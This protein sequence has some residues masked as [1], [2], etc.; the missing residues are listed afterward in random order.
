MV[1][2]ETGSNKID[3]EAA[4]DLAGEIGRSNDTP[5]LKSALKKS[6]RGF[7]DPRAKSTSPAKVLPLK[8]DYKR[9]EIDVRRNSIKDSSS[10]DGKDRIKPGWATPKY[11]KPKEYL[12]GSRGRSA[13]V[14]SKDNSFATN[15]RE[16]EW[17][18]NSDFGYPKNKTLKER[19]Q[20]VQVVT[21]KKIE[22]SGLKSKK[23][24]K[25][26]V[27]KN[28]LRNKPATSRKDTNEEKK[29]LSLMAAFASKRGKEDKPKKL[30]LSRLSKDSSFKDSKTPKSTKSKK[31]KSASKKG[32]Q[33][34]GMP[35]SSK[36][37]TKKS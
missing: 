20:S 33:K 8:K 14:D 36:S 30:N 29:I 12:V 23:S 15:N 11:P 1:S 9:Q 24:L 37:K 10:S 34:I 5:K 31:D 28:L 16:L 19:K 3:F 17:A 7:E 35:E 22:T 6:V 2:V 13:N 21:P 32:K 18:R 25:E 4:K 27:T 26:I